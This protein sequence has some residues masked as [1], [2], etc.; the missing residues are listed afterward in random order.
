MSQQVNADQLL[1]LMKKLFVRLG[2]ELELPIKG[3]MSR[4]LS[5]GECYI[6]GDNVFIRS[7]VDDCLIARGP[8]SLQVLKDFLIWILT[9][10]E[11]VCL[12]SD[13]LADIKQAQETEAFLRLTVFRAQ[14]LSGEVIV[15]WSPVDLWDTL[16][17]PWPNDL[18][19]CVPIPEAVFFLGRLMRPGE[20]LRTA[21]IDFWKQCFFHSMDTNVAVEGA[22]LFFQRAVQITGLGF[23]TLTSR[24]ESMPAGSKYQLDLRASTQMELARYGFPVGPLYMKAIKEAETELTFKTRHFDTHGSRSGSFPLVYID[25]K[26]E[27]VN[28]YIASMERQGV[29][30]YL[31]VH[32]QSAYHSATPLDARAVV[33]K[34]YAFKT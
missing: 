16:F 9:K 18:P 5:E 25:D 29:K 6:G 34:S 19:R 15:P 8:T 11:R 1:T 33:L 4:R 14:V 12:V 30:T 10:H 7:D 27:V 26:P 20:E 28:A 21:W 32:F 23:S 17:V 31:G 13:Y 24:A 3:K 2:K 22:P